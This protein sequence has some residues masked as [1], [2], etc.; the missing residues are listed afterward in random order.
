MIKPQGPAW[1]GIGAQRSG[2]TWFTDLLLQHP[3]MQLSAQKR[4]ELHLLDR[5]DPD[6]AAYRELFGPYAGEWTPYYLR[7]PAVPPIA[8]KAIGQDTVVLVLLRDPIERFASAM[9]HLQTQWEPHDL[10]PRLRHR[11]THLMTSDAVWGGMYAVQLETW[12]KAIGSE[13][14]LVLQ[15]EAVCADPQAHADLVWR[16]LGLVSVSLERTGQA[17][18]TTSG[19]AS[20]QWPDG[21][22]DLLVH[23]YE[24]DI[25]RLPAWGVDLSRWP[26]FG[27][28]AV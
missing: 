12:A 22:Q 3:T 26:S 25:R 21:L 13:R 24:A 18:G 20:W 4:K 5:P 11:L 17:S 14:I 19:K 1:L 10:V 7:S 15:Y 8:A 27:G 9:R 16:R 6:L 23:A 2:T 28:L